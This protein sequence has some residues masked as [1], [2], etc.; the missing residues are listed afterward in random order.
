MAEHHDVANGK[1]DGWGTVH[2][3]DRVEAIAKGNVPSQRK[4]EPKGPLVHRIVAVTPNRE[5]TAIKDVQLLHNVV[6]VLVIAAT[7]NIA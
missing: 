3:V 6:L 1:G 2:Q 4:E 5:D 7:Q